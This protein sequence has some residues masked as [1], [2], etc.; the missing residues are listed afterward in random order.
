MIVQS[1][2]AIALT[3]PAC[4]VVQKHAFSLFTIS[5]QPLQLLCSCGFSQGHLRQLSKHYELDVLGVD[6]NRIRL[7][8]PRNELLHASLLNISH[9]DGH[10]LGF[11]GKPQEVQEAVMTNSESVL[12]DFGN[13]L[14]PQIMRGTLK[15]LQDLAAE[16]KIRC[17]CKH[18]SIGIDLYA[19]KVELVCGFCGSLVIIGASK[20]YDL[21]KLASVS[22]IVME[23]YTVHHLGKWLKPLN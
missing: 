14:D 3:C 6:G 18:P 12:T 21:N 11:I 16:H 22:E 8:V 2:R 10:D 23:P 15:M 20:Q 19:D 5:Q 17:E 7:L 13:F 9:K 1:T 4:Q